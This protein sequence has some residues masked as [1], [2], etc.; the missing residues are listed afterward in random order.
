MTKLLL[1]LILFGSSDKAAGDRLAAQLTALGGA[2]VR[3][4]AGA[5]ASKA[6]ETRGVR[7]ADLISSPE[8]GEQLTRHSTDLIVVRIDDRKSGGDDVIESTVWARGHVERHVSIAAQGGAALDGALRGVVGIVGPMMPE[9]GDPASEEAR[10]PQLVDSGSWTELLQLVAPFGPPS[11]KPKSPRWCYYEVLAL[12]RL[13]RMDSAVEAAARMRAA[14]P[15]HFLT[16]SAASLIPP[17]LPAP[18]SAPEGEKPEEPVPVPA[19][20]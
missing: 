2:N 13:G 3:V 11:P 18:A 9:P 10:L 12:V 8:L 6:L 14:Y 15:E 5:E 16:A 4:L 7:D 17:Q 1:I 19:G 20:K